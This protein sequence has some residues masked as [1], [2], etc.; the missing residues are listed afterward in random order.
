MPRLFPAAA[1]HDDLD[2]LAFDIAQVAQSFTQVAQA[3]LEVGDAED[4]DPAQAGRLGAA[5]EGHEAQRGQ[6]E[7]RVPPVHGME[8]PCGMYRYWNK[9]A[10][11]AAPDNE[12]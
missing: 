1:P 7:Y 6:C 12:V 2:V 4:A 11:A 8:F 5:R 10:L 3:R 9:I